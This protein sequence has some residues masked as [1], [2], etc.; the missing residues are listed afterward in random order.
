[1]GVGLRESVEAKETTNEELLAAVLSGDKGWDHFYQQKIDAFDSSASTAPPAWLVSFAAREQRAYQKVWDRNAADAAADYA[2]LADEAERHD[3]RLA[4]WFRH[5]EGFCYDL[6]DS[7]AQ[8]RK[9][10]VLAAN[11]RLDLGRPKT[12]G[13]TVLASA[14]VPRPT[15]QAKAIAHLFEGKRAK[16]AAMLDKII[17]DLAYGDQ[18]NPVEEALRVL[19]GLLGLDASRPDNEEGTGPDVKWY[20]PPKRAGVALEAKTNKKETSQYQ[21]KDDIG[22]FH[23]HANYITARHPG[24]DFRKVIVGRHLPVSSDCHPP[25]DLRVITL[26]QFK[27]LAG[28]VKS[29]YQVLLE[30]DSGE[31]LEVVAERWIQEL[32]LRWPLCVDG[33]QS[34]LAVDLQAGELDGDE[35]H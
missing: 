6:L 30:S 3:T 24:E 23:D 15:D 7:P 4:A 35:S 14:T 19:G 26:E 12:E 8:A 34:K 1:L 9:A 17:T 31:P 11:V 10:Y 22:Q 28:R 29:L 18:T 5:W 33:L 32:G 2:S 25:D 13:T 16:V 21:K 27:G 20:Y